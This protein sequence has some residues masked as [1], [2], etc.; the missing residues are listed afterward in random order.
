MDYGKSYYIRNNLNISIIF[1]LYLLIGTYTTLGYLG[2][3][4]KY[5]NDIGDSLVYYDMLLVFLPIFY[6]FLLGA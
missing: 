3:L 5:D 6:M 4:D 2:F 1:L